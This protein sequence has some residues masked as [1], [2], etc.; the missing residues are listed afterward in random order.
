MGESADPPFETT[1]KNLFSNS[2][3][4]TLQKV[5]G[6]ELV[7]ESE[8]PL[9]DLNQLN[10]GDPER[11]ACQKL[12]ARASQ[13]W[14][15]FQVINHGIS[16]DILETMRAEQVKLLKKPFLDKTNYKDLNFSAG[17]YRWGT[18]S[19]TCLEQ[20]SWSEAF[21]V[22]LSDV[23]GSGGLNTLSSTM[24]QFATT[25]SELAQ[26]LADILAEEMSH[27]TCFF[28]QT[29]LPTTCYLRLNRYPP[30]PLYPRMSGIIP[31][32]D[33]DFLTVLHQDNIGGLQLVKD[34]RWIAVKPNPQ[35]LIINIGDLLQAW[36]NNVYKSVEHRVV[37][38][39]RKERFSTA[40][41]FCP[42]DDTVIRWSGVEAG[43]YTSFSFG[44]YREQV[45]Q[46]VDIFGHK[47]GLSRFLAINCTK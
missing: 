35:A 41:F 40:F 19:A 21:H 17:S 46:D 45:Q 14:G 13:E 27:K 20:L 31:H 42:A 47:I 26:T 11:Q 43:Y 32:T 18:P 9:V 34:G 12:I 23:L 44:E 29:C 36:S 10:L 5:S 4:S 15:F 25:V 22:S 30:C 8:L 39:P 28:K 37:A 24:E 6:P 2:P 1:Y 16:R 33:S 3:D 38:N 7:E